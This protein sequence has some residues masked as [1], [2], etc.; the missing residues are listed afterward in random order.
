MPAPLVL[1][2]GLLNTGEV[3]HRVID[4]LG[5][6]TPPQLPDLTQDDSMAA[7]A[8]RVLAGAPAEPFALAG[9]SMGG[10]VAL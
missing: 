8:A 6:A 10:Y 2:P 4:A 3:W 7:M 9:L 5:P 1:L